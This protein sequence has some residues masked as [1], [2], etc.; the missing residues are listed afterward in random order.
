MKA[1]S[2]FFCVLASPVVC[3]LGH[4][5]T[6]FA[7]FWYW[8]YFYKASKVI[9][10]LSAELKSLLPNRTVISPQIFTF[11]SQHYLSDFVSYAGLSVCCNL[12]FVSKYISLIAKQNPNI[13]MRVW[14]TLTMSVAGCARAM[15]IH[16]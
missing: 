3:T 5:Y 9:C 12:H 16:G 2:L 7:W 11:L 6:G 10:L 4:L 13:N 8:T 15:L 1:Q 14:P